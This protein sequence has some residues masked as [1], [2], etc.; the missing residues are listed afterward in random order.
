MKYNRSKNLFVTIEALLIAVAIVIAVLMMG[1]FIRRGNAA[2][3]DNSGS[4]AQLIAEETSERSTTEPVAAETSGNTDETSTEASTEAPTESTEAPTETLAEAPTVPP[5]EAFAEPL[6]EA[7]TVPPTEAPT[8][9]PTEPTELPI[10]LP[11]QPAE[12]ILNEYGYSNYIFVGDSRFKAIRLWMVDNGIG[13]DEIFICENGEGYN[14]MLANYELIKAYANSDSAI[15]VGM[16][17]N[18]LFNTAKYIALLNQM[19]TELNCK[20]YFCSVNPVDES[21]TNKRTNAAISA[22]N[23]TVRNSIDSRIIYID[24]YNY[25]LQEGFNSGDG[26]HYD[27]ATYAKIY[28]YIKTVVN[29]I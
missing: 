26:I 12:I 19:A 22:F 25:L 29:N 5:T 27:N 10:V 2:Y 11:T 17:V 16:G 24:T 14:Y 4:P 1:S 23:D 6:T 8:E 20:I 28:Y 15:I 13:L 3:S 7:P 21:K 9:P 18:D